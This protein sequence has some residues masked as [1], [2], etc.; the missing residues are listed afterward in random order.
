MLQSRNEV[1]AE[2]SQAYYKKKAVHHLPAFLS[3]TRVLRRAALGL[4]CLIWMFLPPLTLEFQE[5]ELPW[6]EHS[7]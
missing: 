4:K 7:A 3:S 1:H 2:H 6:V 5:M